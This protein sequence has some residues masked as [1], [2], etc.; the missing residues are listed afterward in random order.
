MKTVAIYPGTFDPITNG[1]VDLIKRAAFIYPKVIVLVAADTRKVCM[2]SMEERV[3]MVR[4]G[5]NDLCPNVQVEPFQGLLVEIVRKHGAKI[6]LRGL[7]AVSDFEYESQ[8]A[9]MNRRLE[10]RIE[11]FFMI[12]SEE[13]AYLS[14]SFVK[15]IASLGGDV[16]TLVPSAV[17]KELRKRFSIV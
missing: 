10:K 16:S 8:M 11:T 14:S 1:H 5:I 4:E 3:R 7:R 12:S 13:Y 2:F 6:I 9:L 17:D 15:E